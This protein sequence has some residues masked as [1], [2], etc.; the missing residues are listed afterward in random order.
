MPGSTK[1]DELLRGCPHGFGGRVEVERDRIDRLV[2]DVR[3]VAYD[4]HV[5]CPREGI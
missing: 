3:Q 2:E 5:Y 1:V 4:V